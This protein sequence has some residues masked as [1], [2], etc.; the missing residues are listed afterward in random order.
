MNL[1]LDNYLNP[2]NLPNAETKLFRDFCGFYLDYFDSLQLPFQINQMEW[3]TCNS[4]IDKWSSHPLWLLS[5]E[6]NKQIDM[7]HV[8]CPDDNEVIGLEEIINLDSK[9]LIRY[10]LSKNWIN[11]DSRFFQ[12]QSTQT[13]Y[14]FFK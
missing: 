12:L 1:E 14:S 5:G 3:G 10:P 2:E 6:N 4:I 11:S 7:I 8:N 13:I 9:F